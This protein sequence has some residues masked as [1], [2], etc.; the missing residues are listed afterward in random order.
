MT[1]EEFLLLIGDREVTIYRLRKQINT[2]TAQVEALTPPA[3]QPPAPEV[4]NGV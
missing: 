2:L 3:P 4:P 1:T